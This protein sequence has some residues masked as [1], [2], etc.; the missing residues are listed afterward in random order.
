MSAPTTDDELQARMRGL[1]NRLRGYTAPHNLMGLL[2][3]PET[4]LA[5][6]IAEATDIANSEPFLRAEVVQAAVNLKSVTK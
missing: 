3:Q 5:Y 4:F 1:V 6:A 2:Q